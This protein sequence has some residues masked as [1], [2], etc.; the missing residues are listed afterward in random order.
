MTYTS[1]GG[2]LKW[3]ERGRTKHISCIQAYPRENK[4]QARPSADARSD[5]LPC[6]LDLGE[7]GEMHMFW[8]AGG[9]LRSNHLFEH[10]RAEHRIPASNPIQTGFPHQRSLASSGSSLR[11]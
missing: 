8:I 1:Q 11:G 2:V 6:E 9:F 7:E 5:E 10:W 4:N 3:G